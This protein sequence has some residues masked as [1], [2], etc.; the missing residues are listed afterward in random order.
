MLSQF[1]PKGQ[2][3]TD[4]RMFCDVLHISV[5]LRLIHI[6]TESNNSLSC[7]VDMGSRTLGH[8]GHWTGR[9]MFWKRIILTDIMACND[10]QTFLVIVATKFIDLAPKENYNQIGI[11][12]I[13]I[14]FWPYRKKMLRC[15]SLLTNLDKAFSGYHCGTYW[16]TWK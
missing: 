13:S 16:L 8:T 10:V 7:G 2:T 1:S 9:W 5:S 15:C 6:I 12:R 11:S 14:M 4:S 3:G